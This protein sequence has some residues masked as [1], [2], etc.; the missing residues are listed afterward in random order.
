MID[1]SFGLDLAALNGLVSG[2]ELAFDP[3]Y[4]SL[5]GIGSKVNDVNIVDDTATVDL[6]LGTL[7]L[8][9]DAEAAAIS[10]IVW[11]LTRNNSTVTTVRFTVDGLQVESIAGHVDGTKAFKRGSAASE[12]NSVTISQPINGQTIAGEVRVEGMACTF[13]ANV[14]WELTQADK[15]ISSGVTLASEACPQNSPWSL[16][17]GKLTK[18]SYVFRGFALSPKD[19]LLLAEDTKEFMVIE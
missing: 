12:L 11:T 5:W 19:G 18:G 9:A 7:S 13:E 4:Q 14:A 17:L 3:D 15:V 6:T 16:N 1:D 2:T 8:G 10:Q